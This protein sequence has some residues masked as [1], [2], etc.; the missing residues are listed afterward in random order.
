MH[1]ALSL[2]N[3]ARKPIL[4][5]SDFNSLPLHAHK[6]C[7]HAFFIQGLLLLKRISCRDKHLILKLVKFKYK[8]SLLE[9][10]CDDKRKLHRK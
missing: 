2:D 1:R 4:V 8:H 6:I 5:L 10:A 7:I 9:L 3:Q